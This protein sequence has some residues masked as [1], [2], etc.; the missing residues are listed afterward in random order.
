[1][2]TNREALR[3]LASLISK[4][5]KA[6]TKLRPETWQ[7]KMLSGNIAA[8]RLAS[9]QMNGVVDS[10]PGEL[11]EARAAL[12][13]MIRKTR[14]ALSKFAPGTAQHTLQL[15]R[16]KALRLARTALTAHGCSSS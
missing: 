16:L 1:M 5:E 2:K 12:A 9:A 11:R 14:Q 3:P 10:S 4:S 8:L 7:H 6:R 15:N 13:S